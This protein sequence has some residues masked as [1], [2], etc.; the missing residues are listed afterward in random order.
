[1]QDGVAQPSE[2]TVAFVYP[3]RVIGTPVLGKFDPVIPEPGEIRR[4][5]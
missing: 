5:I 4:P 2:I 3:P 1:M